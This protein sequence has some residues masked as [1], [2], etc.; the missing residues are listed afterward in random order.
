MVRAVPKLLVRVTAL[1][2]LL[3]PTAIVPKAR[4]AGERETGVSPVPDRLTIWGETTA[5][6]LMVISPEMLPVTE[7]VKVTVI[8]HVAPAAKVDGLNG[9]VL[10]LAKFPLAVIEFIANP[11]LPLLVSVTAFPALVAF[12]N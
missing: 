11:A 6:S 2:A 8:V 1:A 5:L 10:L 4:L 9:H 3:V 7:G 12:S